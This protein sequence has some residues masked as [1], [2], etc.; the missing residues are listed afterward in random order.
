MGRCGFDDTRDSRGD[1]LDS[2]QTRG[3][4]QTGNGT[5]NPDESQTRDETI[6]ALATTVLE[7]EAARRDAHKAEVLFPDDL[8]PGVGGEETTLR[9]GLLKG[10]YRTFLVLL[11]LNSLDELENSA[12]AILGPDIGRS[13]GVSD[14]AITAIS[15]ASL[16]FFVLGAG[17]M[18]WMADRFRRGPIV[19][20]ASGA[21]AAFSALSGAAVNALMFFFARFLTG[22]S[23]AN[24][25]TVH[26]S[27][28]ADTYPL[29]TRGRM[30]A[31]NAGVGRVF[32]ALSPI[33]AGGIA[34]WMGGDDGWRWAFYLLGLP[35][36]ALAVFAFWLREPPRGQWEQ[37]EVLGTGLVQNDKMPI[38]VE[39]A[40]T[41]IWNIDTIRN[42]T[43]AFAAMGFALF[44]AGSIQ[45]F[46]LEEEFGLDAL[47]RGLAVA[48]A[49]IGLM[50]FL[51]VV[52]RRFDATYRQ[53]PDRALRMI[54]VLLVPIGVLV[55][56]QYAMSDLALFMVFAAVNSTLLG[57]AFAMVQ[58]AIQAVFPY[59]LRGMGTAF[60]TFFM[61][62]VG[63]V[64]GSIIAGFLQ[65][66]L[67]EQ[68]AITLITASAMP[69]GAYFVLRGAG[70]L[71]RDLSLIVAELQEEQA[72]ERRRAETDPEEIPAIQVADVDFSYGQVQV[73][74]D[75]GFEVGRQETLAL[76]GTNGAGKST[77]LRV[78]TGLVTPERGVVRLHGQ[79][80]TFATPEQRSAMGL[81]MLPGGAGVWSD[82]SISDNLLMGAYAYRKDSHDRD[83]RI[84]KVFDLFP[85]LAKRPG[86]RAANLSGGQQQMLALARVMLHE[87]EVL[88]IDELSLG[89]AP[90]VVQSL[91]ETV[92]GLK[93][94]GQT[95]IIVE[96]SLNVAL[97]IADRAV[98]L[99]KGQV[100][101][102]GPAQELAERDDLARAVFL[103]TEGG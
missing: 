45:S 17:P 64:G 23:K 25:I 57:G 34:V 91:L 87:P 76:L 48:P 20:L 15:T 4:S 92:E 12:V 80:I 55:P 78:I 26:P 7:G 79:T 63:G 14:G 97:A 70:R 103:G 41:R 94:R 27:M 61:V 77:A 56:I 18:G 54:G 3:E 96:Q 102:E 19:G 99:E 28:L 30:F 90:V 59:R 101:F 43:I 65:N 42:M 58:P 66:E 31:T 62:M 24:T 38:S 2:E 46:F 29:Q 50:M 68:T 33:L 81:H 89:L 22:M 74:F 32:A 47:E 60:L 37:K 13:F 1:Y 83:R 71:R 5:P 35:T 73:L 93:A 88:I 86:E 100:R 40:F 36:A 52:G 98:F 84:E 95:M 9:E 44:P 11:A 51:P 49:G 75:L 16:M 8:L 85:N 10:G 72:E 39:A 69:I 21:F 6:D 53:D 67:G 82:M